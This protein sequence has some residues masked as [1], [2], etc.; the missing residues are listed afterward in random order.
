MQYFLLNSFIEKQ[1]REKGSLYCCFIDLQKCFDSIYRDG[2]WVKLIKN[3]IDGKFFQLIR[4][5]YSEVKLC[6]KHMHKFSDIYDCQVGLL[7][8]EILSP[9]LFSLFINDLETYLQF[10]SVEGFN[11]EQ[12]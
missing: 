1:L 10:N 6:V 5:I 8:G 7:Q 2:L 3:G 12:L 11:F 4:S 9:I